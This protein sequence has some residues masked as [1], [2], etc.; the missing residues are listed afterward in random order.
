MTLP[1]YAAVDFQL[2]APEKPQVQGRLPLS[3]L[4]AK[5][6]SSARR[7]PMDFSPYI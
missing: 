2:R 6:P 3:I 7:K 1:K 4:P 5:F